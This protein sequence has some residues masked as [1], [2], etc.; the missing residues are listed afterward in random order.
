[1]KTL[2]ELQAEFPDPNE[3]RLE[4]TKAL[5]LYGVNM[6]PAR[7]QNATFNWQLQLYE[8][9]IR[10]FIEDEEQQAAAIA[11][12]KA[13]AADSHRVAMYGALAASMEK[14]LITSTGTGTY[15]IRQ[16]MT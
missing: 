16:D 8:F 13:F 11:M 2:P 3:L 15:K 9:I 6:D 12:F 5:N 1:M 10:M 7:H 4:I 14:K